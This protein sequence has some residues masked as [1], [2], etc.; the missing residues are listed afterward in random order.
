MEA[1]R[2][3]VDGILYLGGSS[4]FNETKINNSGL[5]EL[6]E[7]NTTVVWEDGFEGLTR[8]DL[9]EG[10]YS[11]EIISGGD[12]VT[13]HEIYVPLKPSCPD[14]VT[15][16]QNDD[17]FNVYPNPQTRGDIQNFEV[18]LSEMSYVE[19]NLY[20]SQTNLVITPFKGFLDAGV[21]TYEWLG[22]DNHNG[23]NVYICTIT[24]NGKFDSKF[25][26]SSK[27]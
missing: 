27:N 20:D 12:Q 10:T 11:F 2:L 23:H 26:L 21:H 16:V 22:D 1:N 8:G 9:S 14:K 15:Q 6:I 25:V 17:Y 3:N 7:N 13:K 5:I 18:S 4:D 19:V 24:I